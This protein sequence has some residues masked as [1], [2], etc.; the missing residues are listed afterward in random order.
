MT[1]NGTPLSTWQQHPLPPTSTYQ[2]E[3]SRAVGLWGEGRR[4][5]CPLGERVCRIAWAP[6]EE[7]EARL[8]F[9]RLRSMMIGLKLTERLLEWVLNYTLGGRKSSEGGH[10]SSRATCNLLLGLVKVVCFTMY[11]VPRV[12]SYDATISRRERRRAIMEVDAGPVL[13]GLG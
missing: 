5:L 11:G 9:F 4:S 7:A 2:G 1:T 12:W 8:A 6:G 10:R 3:P 13:P